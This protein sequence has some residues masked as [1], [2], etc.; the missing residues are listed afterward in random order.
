M[1]VSASATNVPPG[2]TILFG[3]FASAGSWEAGEITTALT[4]SSKAP[5][6]S[7]PEFT[8]AGCT[9]HLA[10]ASYELTL[11]AGPPAGPQIEARVSVPTTA[12]AGETIRF[13]AT[14]SVANGSGS[15]LTATDSAPAVTVAAAPHRRARCQPEVTS[16]LLV[17]GFDGGGLV[18]GWLIVGWLIVGWL[19]VRRLGFGRLGFGQP[20][21]DGIRPTGNG[22]RRS[23]RR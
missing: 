19:V 12:P 20:G 17:P 5:A 9:C 11:P 3:I 22:Q 13:S 16:G 14:V 6:F 10:S 18:F 23:A 15:P 2:G 21:R 8:I 4:T 1:T 7:A